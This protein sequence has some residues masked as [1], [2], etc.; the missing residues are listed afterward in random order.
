MQ[1]NDTIKIVKENWSQILSTMQ[2]DYDISDISIDIWFKDLVNHIYSFEND[3]ITFSLV[4]KP[5]IKILNTK[6]YHF[7]RSTI[8]EFTGKKIDVAFVHE[9]ELKDK[10]VSA[11]PVSS[12]NNSGAVKTN[13]NPKYTFDTFVVGN[14]NNFAHAACL[15]VAESP[16]EVYNPLFIYGGVGLGKTHLMQSIAHFVISSDSSKKVTY[17]TSEEFMNEMIDAI[18]NQ[19]NKEFREKYRNVD[20]LLIDDIQFISNR[21]STQEEFFHTFNTL[22]GSNKQIVISSDRPPKELTKLEDRIRTRFEQGLQVDIKPPTYETSMAILD[23][24]IEAEGY[25]VPYEVKDFIV[26]NINSN[27]RELEGALNKITAYSKISNNPISLEMAQDILKDLISPNTRREITIEYII[28]VVADHFGISIVDII[29]AKRKADIVYPRQI[30]MYLCREC[31]QESLVSIGKYMG[32]RDHTT[33][34]HGAE[35]I[36]KEIKENENTRNVIDILIKKINPS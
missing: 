12:Y 26:N 14:N 35:K 36:E 22:Y 1:E 24:K 15:A 18:K 28:Q 3:T 4:E 7:I 33:V 25:S 21:E 16:G 29:S 34:I 13:L 27:I 23:K 6:Y 17:I 31:T 19:K 11:A 32:D 20:V 2:Q 30:A 9:N 8:C 5:M 10:K